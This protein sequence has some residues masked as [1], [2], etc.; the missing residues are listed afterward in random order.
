MRAADAAVHLSSSIKRAR[1]R[2]PA[3]MSMDIAFSRSYFV[4]VSRALCL[5]LLIPGPTGATP[6]ATSF[7]LKDVRACR[8]Y[9][10][11][12]KNRLGMMVACSSSDGGHGRYSITP[13]AVRRPAAG[14]P[15]LI[16]LL[17]AALGAGRL[18]PTCRH[19]SSLF[20]PA[21]SRGV[22]AARRR[23]G[24]RT[25]PRHIACCT[26]IFFSTFE[27]NYTSIPCRRRAPPRAAPPAGCRSIC[28]T[29]PAARLPTCAFFHLA[30]AVSR[31][32]FARRCIVV[33]RTARAWPPIF[34]SPISPIRRIYRKLPLSRHRYH[35]LCPQ[36]QVPC[37][38]RYLRRLD[39]ASAAAV[40][41]RPSPWSSRCSHLL[42]GSSI[43]HGRAADDGILLYK[44]NIGNA[45]IFIHICRY[46]AVAD[47]DT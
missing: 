39:D 13:C 25:S 29:S 43:C 3:R 33:C 36:C 30:G 15:L 28:H 10:V 41:V 38:S 45:C 8:L 18:L 12:R 4:H 1:A 5:P 37:I 34:C 40:S 46:A 27:Q 2:A 31:A 16:S 24:E 19:S 47:G 26:C 35:F 11:F 14:L 7:F 22:L 42:H 32:L 23:H 44:Y 9:F 20:A 17:P 6:A 21:P